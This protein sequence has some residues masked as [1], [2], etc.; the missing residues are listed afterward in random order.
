MAPGLH[1]FP[2]TAVFLL[3]GTPFSALS[4]LGYVAETGS[5]PSEKLS[6]SSASDKFH[7]PRSSL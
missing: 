4:F 3:L 6:F 1:A 7:A 2:L 5:L